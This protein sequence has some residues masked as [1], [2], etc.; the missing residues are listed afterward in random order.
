MDKRW[1]LRTVDEN[2]ADSLQNEL[3]IHRSICTILALR[4][5]QTYD[6]AQ[7][8]FRPNLAELPDP[9]LMKG[10]QR[11]VDRIL[12][13]MQQN[14]SIL[15][16]GDYD[17]DGTTAVAVVLQFIK[18]FY[19]NVSY[20][21]PNRFREGYGVSAAGIEYAK[22]HHIDLIITLDCGIKSIA[23]INEAQQYGIDVIICDH[24]L[25][26][27]ILPNAIAILNAKQVDCH[28]PNKELC[29]CG[30]GYKLIC[31]L[32]QTMTNEQ[33]VCNRYLDLVATAIAA[34]IVPITTENRIL[35]YFG[36]QKANENP[37]IAIQALK[38]VADINKQ[39]TISDLVFIVAPRV[40]AAG[41]M[42]DASLAVN[43]FM[44]TEILEAKR[45][46]ALLNSNNDDRKDTDKQMTAEAL[47][48]L[49]NTSTDIKGTVLYRPDWHKGVVGIVASR[50][51]EQRYQPTI[52]LT[53]SNDKVTGSAR[54][55]PGL[56]LFEALNECSDL[57]ENYGG[58]YFAAG[59][60]MQE[61]HLAEFTTRFDTIVK[62]ELQPED[63]MPLLAI[64]AEINFSDITPKYYDIIQQMQP[65]GP[66]NLR[67]IFLT[68]N[69]Q[70]F[71][72]KSNIV[73]EKHLK[74]VVQQNGCIIK[75]IGFNM[76]HYLPLLQSGKLVDICYTLD[77]NTWNN[78]TNIELK[79]LDI[80]PSIQR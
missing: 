43:L 27:T 42:D 29:G 54:S 57:L 53:N 75:G 18:H 22:Q 72:G 14:E 1:E 35:A 55:I 6:E 30:V 62:R 64:D 9:F 80:I 2:I 48:M 5:V 26:D 76:A 51:I 79:I 25:P 58:H 66:E 17:V 45:L 56:N 20:Y 65:Y 12:L 77:A 52:V 71:Q 23:L 70:D 78:Q 28:Y 32:E 7:Q 60:T 4:N 36:L 16:Y 74:I 73:K 37:C 49:Q 8:F 59:L 50:M 41:R 34:D 33:F 13:A 15:L 44:A 10:M 38:Q 67:P 3:K 63:F 69:V 40:N 47:E 31:A 19:A 21:I 39:F 61:K 46:A 11:A 24:H 68:K